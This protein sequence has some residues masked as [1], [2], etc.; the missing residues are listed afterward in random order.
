ML[1]IVARDLAQLLEGGA[2]S[3]RNRAC[4]VEADLIDYALAALRRF[5]EVLAVQV[6]VITLLRHLCTDSLA[7]SGLVLKAKVLFV[8]QAVFERWARVSSRRR[9]AG[10][11]A[12][13]ADAP[14]LAIHH[15]AVPQV[16]RRG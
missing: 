9:A 16:S 11:A 6:E 8:V 5:P 2:T 7:H 1:S 15:T 3:D 12:K 10:R 4:S 13:R 14:P